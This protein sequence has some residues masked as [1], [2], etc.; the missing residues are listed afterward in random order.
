[1]PCMRCSPGV[2][3]CGPDQMELCAP[4]MDAK[5]VSKWGPMK[6]KQ[7]LGPGVYFVKLKCDDGCAIQVDRLPDTPCGWEN[8]GMFVMSPGAAGEYEL[9]SRK[10]NN[11]CEFKMVMA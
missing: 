6:A 8:A 9:Y 10:G 1:M 7:R 11:G 5:D 4:D 2:W 3:E